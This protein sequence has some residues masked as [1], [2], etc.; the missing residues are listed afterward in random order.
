MIS[1]SSV[2]ILISSAH[3]VV[4]FNSSIYTISLFLFLFQNVGHSVFSGDILRPVSFTVCADST[5]PM[6]ISVLSSEDRLSVKVKHLISRFYTFFLKWFPFIPSAASFFSTIKLNKL[7]RIVDLLTSCLALPLFLCA[8]KFILKTYS[9][10]KL[11]D[12]MLAENQF[13]NLGKFNDGC[14]V[15]MKDLWWIN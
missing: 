9:R 8:T 3:L 2:S 5:T 6:D 7:N 12:D 1:T 13:R 10:H 14:S 11:I 15:L 4:A